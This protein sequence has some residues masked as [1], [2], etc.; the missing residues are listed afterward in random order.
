[1]C[2]APHPPSAG[3]WV[4][5]RLPLPAGPAAPYCGFTASLASKLSSVTSARLLP[6]SADLLKVWVRGRGLFTGSLKCLHGKN[7]NPTCRQPASELLRGPG[8][9]GA[10][11]G[12]VEVLLGSEVGAGAEVEG[13]WVSR[14]RCRGGGG[15]P[16]RGLPRIAYPPSDSVGAP[17]Q[18]GPCQN[19]FCLLG[20]IVSDTREAW[21]ILL[22]YSPS[23][24]FSLKAYK[25]LFSCL[26]FGRT[27][28]RARLWCP[29]AS[30]EVGAGLGRKPHT[31]SSSQDS[32][33]CCLSVRG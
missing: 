28:G 33:P 15:G 27:D 4:G 26:L 31:S 18:R 29:D 13:V 21:I 32:G 14:G 9:S 22:N 12:E 3:G 17:G 10:G 19:I 6:L 1:M 30:L 20:P 24:H 25:S 11:A 23:I 5:V 2:P 16:E 8:D 7:Q